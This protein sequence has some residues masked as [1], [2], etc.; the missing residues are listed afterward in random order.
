MSNAM[1]PPP[2]PMPPLGQPMGGWSQSPGEKPSSNLAWAILSTI[3]CCLPLGIVSIVYAARVD[4][5]WFAGRYAEAQDSSRKAKNWA[6][7]SVVATP[8]AFV[9]L[10]VVSAILGLS[11]D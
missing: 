10:F 1:P 11:G 2:P 4:G 7:A 6:I 5:H 3:L 9:L 8:V